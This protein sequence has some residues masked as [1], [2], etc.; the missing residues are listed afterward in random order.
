L[1]LSDSCDIQPLTTHRRIRFARSTLVWS[2]WCEEYK[3]VRNASSEE[4]IMKSKHSDVH[5]T[6]YVKQI[7]AFDF[8]A[9]TEMSEDKVPFVLVPL[10]LWRKTRE[11][12]GWYLAQEPAAPKKPASARR[13]RKKAG[14]A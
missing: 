14:Q 11:V 1:D 8:K 9:N 12:T 3:R 6:D 4:D 7:R 5:V 13:M 2:A 10:S